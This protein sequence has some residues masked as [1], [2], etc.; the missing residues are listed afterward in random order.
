M[1][2]GKKKTSKAKMVTVPPE[3]KEAQEAR[4]S[5][6]RKEIETL[7]TENA[8]ME[9]AE[10][11][12]KL[13]NKIT[14]FNKKEHKNT[15]KR[16]RKEIM[17]E[18]DVPAKVTND[19]ATTKTIDTTQ[20]FVLLGD[21]L[22]DHGRLEECCEIAECTLQEG[23]DWEI[24]ESSKG[25]LGA[26]AKRDIAAGE[27]VVYE[28]ALFEMPLA[29]CDERSKLADVVRCNEQVAAQFW[30]LGEKEQEAMMQ[31]HDF[32]DEFLQSEV[33]LKDPDSAAQVNQLRE[34]FSKETGNK[35]PGKSA[36]GVFLTNCIPTDY[37]GH[38]LLLKISRFN[39]SCSPN[40]HYFHDS[41]NG[42]HFVRTQLPVAAGDEICVHYMPAHPDNLPG[43]LQLRP[44]ADRMKWMQINFGVTCACPACAVGPSERKISDRNRASVIRLYDTLPQCGLSRQFRVLETQARELLEVMLREGCLLPGTLKQVAH[45]VVQATGRLQGASAVPDRVVFWNRLRYEAHRFC[46]GE[47]TPYTQNGKLE[48]EA[49][50]RNAA[51]KRK[52][53]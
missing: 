9:P 35:F 37:G 26:F 11:C 25:G 39:H 32:C 30:L 36:V 42:H 31:L 5:A 43:T 16:L 46:Q 47:T 18:L 52:K 40:A 13:E 27:Y 23:V 15:V 53:N 19:K 10:I 44:C 1:P 33:T 50:M 49:A 8:E 51:K 24:R 7:L 14:N 48:A 17:V 21:P 28:K 22:S 2:A 20:E 34:D 29:E 12:E 3:E 4:N 41:D 38:A 6:M 45:D